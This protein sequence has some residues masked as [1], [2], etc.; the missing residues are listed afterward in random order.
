MGKLFQWERTNIK[1]YKIN[2]TY[3][4]KTNNTKKYT[5]LKVEKM[6]EEY[7]GKLKFVGN[8]EWVITPG[9]GNDSIQDK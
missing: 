6:A 7:E 2:D 8:N 3:H 1:V 9:I 4:L 5:V